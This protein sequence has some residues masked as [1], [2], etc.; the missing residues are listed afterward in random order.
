MPTADQVVSAECR[1]AQESVTT[2]MMAIA[3]IPTAKLTAPPAARIAAQALTKRLARLA[4]T[5]TTAGELADLCW[6]IVSPVAEAL[7]WTPSI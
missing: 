4:A 2:A 6:Y 3:A 1:H 5:T 7:S